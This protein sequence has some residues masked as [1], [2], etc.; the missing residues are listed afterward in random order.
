MDELKGSK[1]CVA[2]TSK[3]AATE[4]T[5]GGRQQDQQ[6]QRELERFCYFTLRP[7]VS[8]FWVCRFGPV[9]GGD[10]HLLDLNGLSSQH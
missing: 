4:K 9:H 7:L 8:I 1:T 3:P 2:E 10:T 5:F 6:K